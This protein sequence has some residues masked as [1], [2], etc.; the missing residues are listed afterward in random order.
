MVEV[1]SGRRDATVP[2]LLGDDPD[3]HALG[4]ELGRVR[5]A[6]AVGVHAFVN[7]GLPTEP[8]QEDAHVA[9]R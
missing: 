9:W 7:A 2:E 1:A 3:V 5:V 8:R 4:A 6:Q